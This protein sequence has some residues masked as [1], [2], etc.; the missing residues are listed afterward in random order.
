[1]SVH[2]VKKLKTQYSTF[3]NKNE[4]NHKIKKPMYIYVKKK[5]VFATFGH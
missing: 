5:I 3:K 2:C 1:M 4:E